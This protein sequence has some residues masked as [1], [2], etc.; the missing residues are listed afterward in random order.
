M[1]K[2]HERRVQLVFPEDEYR[3][4]EDYARETERSLGH[5]VRECVERYLLPEVEARRKAI[6]LAWFC[7]PTEGAPVADWEEMERELERGRFHGQDRADGPGN[8][9]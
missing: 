9:K 4:L 6:A 1:S 5:V 3:I 8:G 2:P 7:D